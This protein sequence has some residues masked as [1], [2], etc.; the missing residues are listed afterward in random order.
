MGATTG[1]ALNAIRVSFGPTTQLADVNEFIMAF[2]AVLSEKR[3]RS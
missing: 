2:Q 3:G 1:E